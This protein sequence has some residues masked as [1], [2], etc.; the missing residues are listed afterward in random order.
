LIFTPDPPHGFL[1]TAESTGK[2]L[3]PRHHLF[4]PV[5]EC[6][7]AVII[8]GVENRAVGKNNAHARDGPHAV[9]IHTT[10]HAAGVVG[11]DTA[12]PGRI[13]GGRIRPEFFAVGRQI[14]I[15]IGTQNAG[16]QGNFTAIGTD[17][18]I[19]PAPN[20]QQYQHGSGDRLAG[21]A[22]SGRTEG[23]GQFEFTAGF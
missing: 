16:P 15:G 6:L 5:E 18:A 3:D 14:R 1:V 19:P 23:N 20:P 10:G 22:R 12:D 21:Q 13:D 8:S 9:S 2:F 11:Y 4:S 7:A 17:A